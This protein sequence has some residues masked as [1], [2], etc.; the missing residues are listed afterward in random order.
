MAIRDR[1]YRWL[2]AVLYARRVLLLECYRRYV[3]HMTKSCVLKI[4]NLKQNI[5]GNFKEVT[6]KPF[7]ASKFTLKS[8]WIEL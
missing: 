5:D 2:E 3:S 7:Q 1:E 8:D 4:L 6:E